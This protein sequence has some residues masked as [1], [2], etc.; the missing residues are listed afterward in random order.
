MFYLLLSKW[1]RCLELIGFNLLPNPAHKIKA[2]LIFIF[3]FKIL[4]KRFF[5][6]LNNSFSLILKSINFQA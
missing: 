4:F 3:S 5:K 2:V 6:S 1:F